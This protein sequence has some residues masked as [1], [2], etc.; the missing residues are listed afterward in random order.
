MNK[1]EIII[2]E[3][4]EELYGEFLTLLEKMLDVYPLM[5]ISLSGGS[6]PIGLFDY[7]AKLPDKQIN[8]D[9]TKYFWVDERCV[10]SNHEMSNFGN[11]RDHF[12]SKIT[13]NKQKI[14]KRIHGENIPDE[15]ADW[16]GKIL[17]T[18]VMLKNNIPSFELIILGLG[19]DGHTASIFP[20]NIELWNDKQLC[21]VS[22]DL[23]T[24]TKRISI[25]G[26]VINNAQHV[27]FL[28]TGKNK[29]GIVKE[30]IENREKLEDVYPAAR[31]EP[32]F[33]N[34]Y[35]FLDKEAASL[36]EKK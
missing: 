29:A 13:H 10:P 22:K 18:K 30:I 3:T 7:L 6:T 8:W 23:K 34:L 5:N 20:H 25:T 33:G 31:V 24:K 21:V 4:K 14:W 16:Y 11:A 19:E 28:V 27:I 17:E 15:E 2:K 9:R 1:Q 35:W 12:F 26:K 32:K 36:L